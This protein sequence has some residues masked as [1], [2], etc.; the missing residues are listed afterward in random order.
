[1]ADL[2]VLDQIEQ[3]S[4]AHEAPLLHAPVKEPGRDAVGGYRPEL[5]VVRFLAFFL[6]FLRHVLPD[7]PNKI[8]DG[9]LAFLSSWRILGAL[10][11]ACGVGL[12]L[13]FTLSAYLITDLLLQERAQNGA[14]SVSKFYIRRALRIWPLYFLG[15]LIGV[16]WAIGAHQ[17]QDVRRFAYYLLFAGNIYCAFYGW[18]PS[19]MMALWS[20]SIEEQFYLIFPWVMRWCSRRAIMGC[21]VFFLL[22]ANAVL[23]HLGQVH[24]DV[25]FAVWP[26]TFVQFEMFATGILLALAKKSVPRQHPRFGCVLT[27]VGPV[28]WVVAC[29]RFLGIQ[30]G[31]SQFASSGLGLMTRYA[32]FA[33]GCAAV[34]QGFCMIGPLPMPKWAADLGKISY[35]LYV[36]HL[37]MLR[38]SFYVYSLFSRSHKFVAVVPAFF[39]TILT[40][41]YSYVWFERPFLR[42]K[43]QFEI[44][45][46]KPI[47]S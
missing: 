39:F 16:F 47:A 18:G 20:I 23:F 27:V 44:L 9:S 5:D 24:A 35:G 31:Q 8:H 10:A 36:Y 14:I 37:L 4:G 33:I 32:F 34:L 29:D 38:I 22:V 45:H 43:R 3:G 19:P 2:P 11:N 12:C 7:T 1:M 30:S 25:E 26:N 28:L 6:V 41:R 40:A 46:T 17:P 42:R 21:A 13:F 15:L